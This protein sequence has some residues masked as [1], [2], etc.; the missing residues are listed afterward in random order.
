MQI[1]NIITEIIKSDVT[2]L[3]KT[4]ASILTV[5]IILALIWYKK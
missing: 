1:Q 2:Q 5:Q 3:H 4:R